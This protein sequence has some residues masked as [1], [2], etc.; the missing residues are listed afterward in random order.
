M[1]HTIDA[2]H[3]KVII[4]FMTMLPS[5]HYPQRHYYILIHQWDLYTFTIHFSTS[6]TCYF[7]PWHWMMGLYIY[8]DLSCRFIQ[9]EHNSQDT[10]LNFHILLELTQVHIFGLLLCVITLSRGLAEVKGSGIAHIL[11]HTYTIHEQTV[12]GFMHSIKKL[13]SQTKLHTS[14][15]GWTKRLTWMG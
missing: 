10:G 12:N 11:I 13:I 2:K 4:V 15:H 5:D 6:R 3:K 7:L 14:A 9:C 8:T 1:V